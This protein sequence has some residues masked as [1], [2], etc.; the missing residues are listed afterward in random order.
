[1]NL[2]E[3]RKMKWAFSA[4]LPSFH[5]LKQLALYLQPSSGAGLL[6]SLEAGMGWEGGSVSL[7]LGNSF[8]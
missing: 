4:A 6:E 7:G 2:G 5:R 8:N 1:M 3:E